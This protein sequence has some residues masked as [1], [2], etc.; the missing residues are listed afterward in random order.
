MSPSATEQCPRK[1]YDSGR[2][3]ATKKKC[4]CEPHLCV[5]TADSRKNSTS[6]YINLWSTT[7]ERKLRLLRPTE[8][9]MC[10]DHATDKQ[11]EI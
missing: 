7:Q 9:L 10:G 11:G 3:F 1:L 8:G 5:Q 6:K 2:M 4:R